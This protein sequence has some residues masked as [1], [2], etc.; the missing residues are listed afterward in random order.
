MQIYRRSGGAHHF[1]RR[2]STQAGPFLAQ[3]LVEPANQI[4]FDRQ[5]SNHVQIFAAVGAEGGGAASKQQQKQGNS[6][7]DSLRGSAP[8]VP[9]NLTWLTPIILSLKQILSFSYI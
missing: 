7:F 1:C 4:M 6:D 8:A 9:G 2:C 3:H 5:S